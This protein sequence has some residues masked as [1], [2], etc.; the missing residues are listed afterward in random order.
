MY[1]AE[2][3]FKSLPSQFGNLRQLEELD[4]SGCDLEML[5]ES[6]SQCKS[7]EKLWLSNNRWV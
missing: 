6:M 7:L 3:K 1:I 2:N 4:L 5:P